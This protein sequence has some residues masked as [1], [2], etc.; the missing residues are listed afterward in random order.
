LGLAPS[1]HLISENG[2]LLTY[3]I[4]RSEMKMGRFFGSMESNKERLGIEDYSIAQPTLEQVFIR[5]VKR[6][7][8]QSE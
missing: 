6:Y 7:D 4:P 2:G 5:T 8:Q 3:E 1:S